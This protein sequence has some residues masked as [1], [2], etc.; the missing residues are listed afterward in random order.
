MNDGLDETIAGI[1]AQHHG[2]FARQHLDLLGVSEE[3][4]R[5]RLASG[6]W[7]LIHDCA[8]RIAGAPIT[9]HAT[10]LAACWA[11]GTRA[12]ASHRSAAALYDL[13]GGRRDA[14]EI[15]CPRWRRARHGGL[16]VHESRLLTTADIAFVHAIPCTTIERTLFDI[17][18]L[19]KPRTLELALDAALRR[20]LTSFVSLNEAA[21]RIAKRGRRGSARFRAALAARAPGEAVP[22]SAP[23]RLLAILLTH[24]G[25]PAP[26]F[27]HVVRDATGAF[28]ARVDLAYPEW[29]ILVEYDSY[30][31]HV[32][33]L[34]LV[35]DSARR[36]SLVALGFTTLT[37]T[38]EDLK[39]DARELA[40]AIRRVRARVA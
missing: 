12:V 25:L 39:G 4:R 22:E 14:I 3:T 19:G 1:A 8:Y 36:N 28:V 17:S 16:V 21:D 10:L 24:Q 18:G 26:E 6:R 33:R 15:T 23:E 11:G 7:Q 31:E 27:Q 40:R 38:P 34:A 30:Q 32:G 29:K 35:R 5:H 9:W 2:L 13:P 37:A 20:D